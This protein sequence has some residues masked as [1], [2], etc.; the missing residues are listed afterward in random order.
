MHIHSVWSRRPTAS[1][2]VWAGL[3]SLV[4]VLS[5]FSAVPWQA[6]AA[7][8]ASCGVTTAPA[9][10]Y[11]LRGSVY[12]AGPDGRQRCRLTVPI[13]AREPQLVPGGRFVA[14]LSGVGSDGSG[15][16]ATNLPRLVRVGGALSS[17]F[18]VRRDRART[19]VSR[20]LCSTLPRRSFHPTGK[21]SCSTRTIASGSDRQ[22][23]G[24]E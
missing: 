14:F 2:R 12:R 13:D 15:N 3:T 1:A 18:V 17:G 22:A 7:G 10:V 24:P 5:T 6:S 23:T 21:S 19:L 20:F 4:L 9:L 8:L 11:A 16:G